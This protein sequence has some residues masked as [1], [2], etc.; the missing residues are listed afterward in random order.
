V[1]VL[2]GGRGEAG[3]L[4]DIWEWDG[5][6]WADRTPR[7][8]LIPAA[9]AGATLIYDAARARVVLFGG[10]GELGAL[11]DTWEW[12]GI[13]WSKLSLAAAPS[14]R[15]HQAMAYDAARAAAIAFG[16]DDGTPLGLR[17]TWFL[18]YDDPNVPAEACQAG[19]DSDGDGRTGCDDPDCAAFCARCGDGICDRP[20]TSRLCPADCEPK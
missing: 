6:A 20:E 14:P 15:H 19:I 1:A 3:R 18:R 8:V 5:T 10:I 11:S 16:G 17:D 12:D 7:S 2:F 9:R 4:G 13:A